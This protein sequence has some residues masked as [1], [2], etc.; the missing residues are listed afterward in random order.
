MPRRKLPGVLVGG[1]LIECQSCQ[2]EQALLAKFYGIV[3]D[4]LSLI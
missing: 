3:L 2:L 4:R 1:T